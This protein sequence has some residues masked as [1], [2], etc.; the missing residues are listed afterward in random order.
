MACQE[1][2]VVTFLLKLFQ[3]ELVI[4]GVILNRVVGYGKTG[5]AQGIP[6]LPGSFRIIVQ[7]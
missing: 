5:R 2:C 4:I 7:Q 6:Y 3:G 1:Q